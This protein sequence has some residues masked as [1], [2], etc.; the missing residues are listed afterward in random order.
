MNSKSFFLPLFGFYYLLLLFLIGACSG[1]TSADAISTFKTPATISPEE[2]VIRFLEWYKSNRHELNKIPLVLNS[3][4][5]EDTTKPYTVNFEG[6]EH[7]LSELKK[8]G[9]LSEKYLSSWRDYFDK[10]AQN[11]KVNPQ[12]E[13]PPDY[14]DYDFI[15]LSQDFTE[16]L[17]ELNLSNA[18]L[19][20]IEN[21]FAY[22]VLNFKVS[23]MKLSYQLSHN[24]GKW[25]IDD[26]QNISGQE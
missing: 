8:C 12:F 22:V 26:I 16:E 6:T 21:D 23:P 5:L 11:W 13:G 7:Y 17:K 20:Q 4:A 3:T 24:G 18:T 9:Y 1:N 19:N 15:M 2:T 14:F 25:Q 10:A